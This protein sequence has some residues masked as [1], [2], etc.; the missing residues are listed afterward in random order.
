VYIY[1]NTE[2][3]EIIDLMLNLNLLEKHEQTIPKSNRK[4]VEQVLPRVV[5]TSGSGEEVGKGCK[6]VNMVQIHVHVNING[7]KILVETIS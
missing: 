5:N 7:K 6:R 3:A 2:R 1:K 4:K